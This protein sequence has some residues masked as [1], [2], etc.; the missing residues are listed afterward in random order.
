MNRKIRS[1]TS[2]KVAKKLLINIQIGRKTNDLICLADR[3]LVKIK[4]KNIIMI[5][6]LKKSQTIDNVP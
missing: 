6:M 4:D 3:C 5:I 1:R 2:G